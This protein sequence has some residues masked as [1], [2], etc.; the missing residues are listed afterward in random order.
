MRPRTCAQGLGSIVC[1]LGVGYVPAGDWGGGGRV[2]SSSATRNGPT[3]EQTMMARRTLRKEERV[4]VQG[5]VRKSAKDLKSH[6]E[7]SW[8]RSPSPPPPPPAANPLG[9]HPP[10]SSKAL[11]LAAATP[12][13]P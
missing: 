13:Q 4:T 11:G 5:P 6:G 8:P 2:P 1:L 10:C 9:P 12:A 3:A 7:P